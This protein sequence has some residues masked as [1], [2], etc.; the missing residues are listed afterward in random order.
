[1]FGYQACTLP[2]AKM[3]SA[4]PDSSFQISGIGSHHQHIFVVISF[5]NQI[6]GLRDLLLHDT[7]N[8]SCVSNQTEDDIACLNPLSD[9]VATVVGHIKRCYDHIA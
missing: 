1:M 6:V 7:G 8:M 4:T 9:A 5:Q 2:V 3:A